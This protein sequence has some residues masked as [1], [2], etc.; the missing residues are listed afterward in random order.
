MI[1]VIT[2]YTLNVINL[3]HLDYE[4]LKTNNSDWFCKLCTAEILPFCSNF[5]KTDNRNKKHVKYDGD[6]L[7]LL[8]QLNNFLSEEKSN[9]NK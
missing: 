2:G 4:Y 7:I 3:D 9:D 1:T 6:L 5:N 8:D